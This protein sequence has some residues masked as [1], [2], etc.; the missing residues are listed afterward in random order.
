MED[1][2]V[3]RER[4]FTSE[5]AAKMLHI[6]VKSLRNMCRFRRMP[7][8]RVGRKIIITE[9]QLAAFMRSNEVRVR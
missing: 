9:S 4:W 6:C 5:E 7:H 3:L 2:N 8:T 1:A